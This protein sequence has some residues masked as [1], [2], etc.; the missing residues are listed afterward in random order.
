MVAEGTV[1]AARRDGGHLNAV[2]CDVFLMCEARIRRLTSY[3][4]QVTWD[5]GG[6]VPPAEAVTPVGLG[7]YA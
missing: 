5:I 3:L 4:V 7:P 6:P 2:F 1:R